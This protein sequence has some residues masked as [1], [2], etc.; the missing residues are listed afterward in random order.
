MKEQERALRKILLTVVE[1]CFHCHEPFQETDIRLLNR[2]GETWFFAL[3][4]RH[5]RTLTIVGLAWDETSELTPT[6]A[7][8]FEQMPPVSR[9]EVQA[10]AE[11]LD[12]FDGDFHQIFRGLD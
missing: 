6:E 7:K 3:K 5:C 1:D 8:R 11:F 12:H 2:I 4:C 9:E 10:T